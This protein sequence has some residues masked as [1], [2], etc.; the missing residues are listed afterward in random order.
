MKKIFLLLIS[1]FLLFFLSACGAAK[2]PV[3]APA[4]PLALTMAVV[5]QHD[6][7][8]DCWIVTNN[9]IYDITDY[10][11]EYPGGGQAIIALCGKDSTVELFDAWKNS[12]NGD[13]D[14]QA[15][16]QYYIGDLAR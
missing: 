11:P 1:Y 14:R 6:T 5:S 3:A 4:P 7:S 13:S 2:T 10:I 8:T 9:S 15:F 16:E 12:P